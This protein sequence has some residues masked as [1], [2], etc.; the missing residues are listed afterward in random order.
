MNIFLPEPLQAFADGELETLL[1]AGLNS[2]ATEMTAASWCSIRQEALAS[3]EARRNASFR[4][5]ERFLV[6]AEMNKKTN[7]GGTNLAQLNEE[8]YPLSVG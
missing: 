3:L 6:N 7:L 4:V 8:Q 2:P 5:A 1:L